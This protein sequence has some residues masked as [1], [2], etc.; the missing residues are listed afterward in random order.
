MRSHKG[1]SPVDTRTQAVKDKVPGRGLNPRGSGYIRL[2]KCR[3]TAHLRQMG[4]GTSRPSQA[5]RLKTWTGHIRAPARLIPRLRDQVPDNGMTLPL[6][7]FNPLLGTNP[8]PLGHLAS[9]T[10]S[11]VRQ[12]L[13]RLNFQYI[14]LGMQQATMKS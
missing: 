11:P 8:Q 5:I 9:C 13:G 7:P 2:K 6:A 14:T 12:R 10:M 4:P 1:T 3:L